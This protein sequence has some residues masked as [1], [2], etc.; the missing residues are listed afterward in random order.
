MS[1]EKLRDLSPD[2]QIVDALER[3]AAPA[4]DQGMAIAAQQ[5]VGRWRRADRAVEFDGSWFGQVISRR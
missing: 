4:A 2:P 5:R 1:R 3:R